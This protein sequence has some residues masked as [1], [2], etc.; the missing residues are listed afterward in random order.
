[1]KSQSSGSHHE[2][3]LLAYYNTIRTA[4]SFSFYTGLLIVKGHA[5]QELKIKEEHFSVY[6]FLH[7][8]SEYG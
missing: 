6:D 3:V 8:F 5:H 7:I 1:M 2:K 4:H